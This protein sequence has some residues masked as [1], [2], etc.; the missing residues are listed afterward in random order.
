MKYLHLLWIVPLG[1]AVL[2]VGHI[3]GVLLMALRDWECCQ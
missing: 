3:V 1:M 2:Y